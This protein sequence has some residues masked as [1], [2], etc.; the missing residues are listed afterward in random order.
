MLQFLE[1]TSTTPKPAINGKDI[2]ISTSK[3]PGERARAKRLA[4]FKKILIEFKLAEP[5]KIKIVYKRAIVFVG[6]HRVAELQADDEN[7]LVCDRSKLKDAGIDVDPKKLTDALDE[8][9]RE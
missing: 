8:L 1:A 6:K 7:T 3:S 5:L 2:W 4:K 9:M